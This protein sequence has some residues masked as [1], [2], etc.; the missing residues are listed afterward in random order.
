MVLYDA[1]LTATPAPD[2]E[3]R[4]AALCGKGDNLLILGRQDAK[5]FEAAIAAFDQLAA[6][7]G[8][9]PVWRNQALFK[10]GRGLQNLGRSDE[11][12][13]AWYDVLDKTAPEGR[14]FFWYYKAGFDAADLFRRQEQWKSAV[15]IY[16]KIAKIPGPRAAEARERA[17][18]LKLEKFLPWD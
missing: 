7:P 4:S 14:D 17:A 11:A 5:Q 12:L 6:L 16:E 3:L 1:I 2:A 8:V 10:K 9:A 15:G 13:A 18:Q